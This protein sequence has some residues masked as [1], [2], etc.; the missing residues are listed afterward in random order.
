MT[1]TAVFGGAQMASVLINLLRGKLVAIFL[2]ST[3]LGI[4]SLLTNASSTMQELALLGINT[5]AVRNISTANE[6]GNHAVLLRTLAIVRR[7]ILIAAIVGMAITMLLSP[8]LS[9]SSFGTYSQTPLYLLLSGVVLLNILG[10]GEYVILQGTRRYRQLAICSVVTPLCGL[11]FGIPIYYFWGTDGILPAMLVVSLL[12][13]FVI[14]RLTYRS[15]SPDMHTDTERITLR[16]VWAEGKN[17]V[18]LGIIMTAATLLGLL[19]TYAIAAYISNTGTLSDVGLFQ[20]AQSITAQYTGL[21]FAAMAADYYPHLS[22]RLSRSRNQAHLL[23]NQQT[24][25]VM[26]VVV[27]LV[28]FVI[29]TAPLIIRILLT[30]EFMPVLQI[31]RFMGFAAILRSFCFPIDYIALAKGDMKYFFWFEGVWTNAKMLTILLVFYHIYGL[32]GLGYGTLLSSAIDLACSTLLTRWRFGFRHSSQCVWLVI[33]LVGFATLCFAASFIPSPIASYTTM[34]V[35]TVLAI[36]YCLRQLDRRIDLRAAIA[37]KL[38]KK[39]KDTP[40]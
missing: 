39:E 24:E 27:P 7:L 32:E 21:V 10:V 20:T 28:M 22:A 19:T 15:A 30:E 18:Q 13:Y 31:I 4:Q 26:L 16:Q 17:I 34:A 8:V 14:R 33:R 37:A 9:K 2:G 29:L 3:G 36:W 6:G 23:V 40:Q 25:I 35:V 38:H 5:T 1:S 11:L 12:Y